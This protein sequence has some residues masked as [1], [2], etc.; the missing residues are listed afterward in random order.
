MMRRCIGLVGRWRGAM[1]INPNPT[2]AGSELSRARAGHSNKLSLRAL[3]QNLMVRARSWLDTLLSL[4]Y[5][6]VVMIFCH[7]FCRR[8]SLAVLQQRRKKGDRELVL[9]SY[10]VGTH[11]FFRADQNDIACSRSSATKPRPGRQ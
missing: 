6:R 1:P 5:A 9:T 7:W 11:R 10:L 3:G 4:P 8:R 2:S